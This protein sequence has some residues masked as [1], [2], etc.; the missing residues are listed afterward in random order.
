VL[1]LSISAA[2]NLVAM[3]INLQQWEAAWEEKTSLLINATE[4]ARWQSKDS[5]KPSE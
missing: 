1:L 2:A 4:I 3:K 5:A